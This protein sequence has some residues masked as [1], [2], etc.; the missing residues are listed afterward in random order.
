VVQRQGSTGYQSASLD[1]D[2]DL[3]TIVDIVCI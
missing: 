2:F 1:Y 3:L